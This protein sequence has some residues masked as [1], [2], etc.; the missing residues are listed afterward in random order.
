[1]ERGR[2]PGAGY[3]LLGN[4]NGTAQSIRTVLDTSSQVWWLN[5]TVTAALNVGQAAGLTPVIAD[6]CIIVARVTWASDVVAL[7]VSQAVSTTAQTC[8][9]RTKRVRRLISNPH[10]QEWLT[11]VVNRSHRTGIW[12]FDGYQP[13]TCGCVPGQPGVGAAGV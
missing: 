13:G 11:T 2:V 3:E 9:C 10:G 12:V 4:G 6:P 5:K 8:A 1:M 7:D